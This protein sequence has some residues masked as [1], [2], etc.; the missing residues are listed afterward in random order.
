M[1]GDS[2]DTSQKKSSGAL[3]DLAGDLLKKAVS[4]GAA[5]YISAEDKVSRT[6]SSV[7]TP[8]HL[9]KA[10]LKEL[11]ENFIENYSVEVKA[12]INFSPKKKTEATE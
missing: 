3:H 5:T 10:V 8:L 12:S 1:S 2:E 7:Q 11:L 4:L 6:I 9:P